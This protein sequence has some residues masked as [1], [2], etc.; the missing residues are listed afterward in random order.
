LPDCKENLIED[1]KYEKMRWLK[2]ASFK[3]KN[4]L[5]DNISFERRDQLNLSILRD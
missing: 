5:G 4:N 1:E 3:S 2:V